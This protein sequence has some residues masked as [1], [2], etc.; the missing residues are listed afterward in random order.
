MLHAVK[1]GMDKTIDKVESQKSGDG[2]DAAIDNARLEAYRDLSSMIGN[3]I[4][5]IDVS[6]EEAHGT[7]AP[8]PVGARTNFGPHS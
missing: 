4:D 7:P 5:N 6:H 1:D 3:I 8:R 2:F